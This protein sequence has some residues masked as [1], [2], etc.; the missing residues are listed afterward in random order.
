[1]CQRKIDENGVK[2]PWLW[3]AFK[4]CVEQFSVRPASLVAIL[5]CVWVAWMYSD[6][7]D[8]YKEE[9]SE[10]KALLMQQTDALQKISERLSVMECKLDKK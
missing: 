6:M 8:S 4:W 2:E 10:W 1:M 9:R 5:C 3:F 7:R